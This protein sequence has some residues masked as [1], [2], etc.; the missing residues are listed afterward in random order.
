[1]DHN[2]TKRHAGVLSTL[3]F[4]KSANGHYA[5]ANIAMEAFLCK[6]FSAPKGSKIP[7]SEE[8]EPSQKPFCKNCHSV[9]DPMAHFMS[10]WPKIGQD[11]FYYDTTAGI[12]ATG[13]FAGLQGG[14][15]LG[16]GKVFSSLKDFE[17]CAVKHSFK[18]LVERNIEST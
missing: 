2:D 14:D 17:T 7:P 15:T 18:F 16:M 4:Q 11:N 12:S 1:M 9:L 8:T 5:K 6:A 3:A 10:R 13:I